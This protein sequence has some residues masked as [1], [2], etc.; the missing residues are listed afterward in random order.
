MFKIGFL[1]VWVI[2]YFIKENVLVPRKLVCKCLQMKCLNVYNFF[3]DFC[4]KS[5]KETDFY[6]HVHVRQTERKQ[7]WRHSRNKVCDCSL[8]YEPNFPLVLNTW[9]Q[10]SAEN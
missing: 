6:M 8:Q 9:K 2:V 3:K 5:E 10:R 4:K 7:R 1:G